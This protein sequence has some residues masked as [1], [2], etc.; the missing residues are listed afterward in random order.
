VGLPSYCFGL[1]RAGDLELAQELEEQFVLL[2]M[3]KMDPTLDEGTYQ[4]DLDQDDW[5]VRSR[6]T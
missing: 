5:Y 2:T 4:K 6:R 3:T 1:L